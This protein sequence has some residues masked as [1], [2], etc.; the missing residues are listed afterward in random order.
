MAF[1]P[2]NPLDLL[3]VRLST[4]SKTLFTKV[5][6]DVLVSDHVLNLS[7]HGERKE[8]DKVDNQ[9]GPKDGNVKDGKHG[10]DQGVEE[11]CGA[12][13]PELKFR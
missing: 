6:W 10:G 11:A 9:D 5:K 12:I 1:I 3:C 2:D 4:S 8:R 13:K 7:P